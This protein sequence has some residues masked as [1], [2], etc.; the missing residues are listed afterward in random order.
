MI[1]RELAARLAPYL[2]WAPQNGDWF[3]IPR[4]EIVDATFIV[5]DMVVE[6]VAHRDH[7]RFHFNGTTE[8]A[9]DSVECRE[10]VWLPAE[11]QLRERLGTAFLSLDRVGED[12]LV[13]IRGP[14]GAHHT[15]PVPDAAD[16]Y[17]LALL[18]VVGGDDSRPTGQPQLQE[19]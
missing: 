12:Y 17:A 14:A 8:W 3:F 2:A 16:A 15:E 11:H 1:S 6:H 13:S 18:H 4:A 19:A 9:L 5:S 7:P 10:V